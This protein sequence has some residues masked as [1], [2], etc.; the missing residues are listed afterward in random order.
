MLSYLSLFPGGCEEKRRDGW[1]RV[2]CADLA[3]GWT[4]LL[5]TKSDSSSVRYGRNVDVFPARAGMVLLE[6]RADTCEH[7]ERSCLEL[8]GDLQALPKPSQGSHGPGGPG[9]WAWV[10]KNHV[11][12]HFPK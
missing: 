6:Q 4:F 10:G 9:W 2:G 11:A 7:G 8:P 1:E 5:L 3:V 12:S